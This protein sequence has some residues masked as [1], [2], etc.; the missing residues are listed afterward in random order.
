MLFNIKILTKFQYNG[1]LSSAHLIITSSIAF[2]IRGQ[3]VA[4]LAE[5]LP[6]GQIQRVKVLRK[7]IY[8]LSNNVFLLYFYIFFTNKFI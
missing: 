2:T 4:K 8:L 3:P 6:G 7:K 5:I 1:H